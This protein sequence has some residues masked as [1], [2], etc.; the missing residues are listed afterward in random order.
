MKNFHRV[1]PIVCSRMAAAGALLLAV[2]CADTTSDPIDDAELAA[3]DSDAE[4]PSTSADALTQHEYQGAFPG[5]TVDISLAGDDVVLDW[6]QAGL[7]GDGT[8]YRSEDP[9][10]LADLSAGD[11]PPAG[12]VSLSVDPGAT[13]LVDA[14]AAS[15]SQP[16]PLYYYRVLSESNNGGA[17]LSTMVMK[18]TTATGSG[19]NKFGLCMMN[20]FEYAKDLHSMFGDSLVAIYR[21]DSVSQSYEGW[22]P[23]WGV[24]GFE[25]GLGQVFVAQ[26]DGSAPAFHSMVGVVPTDEEFAV[27]GESGFNW[28][29]MPAMYDG[30]DA[31]YW[32]EEAGF[33]GVARWNNTSQ[34]K[35][36][37]WGE[38]YQEIPMEACGTYD[39]V[40]PENACTKN[41]DCDNGKFCHFVEEATCGDTAPGLCLPKPLGCEGQ[42][43]PVCGCDEQTYDSKCDAH[44]AGVS[45]ASEGECA[46][47]TDGDGDPDPTDCAPDD[48]SIHAG[49]VD[50]CNGLDDDCDGVADQDCEAPA[51]ELTPTHPPVDTPASQ[52]VCGRF[53]V[54]G[55]MPDPHQINNL[56]TYMNA[57]DNASAVEELHSDINFAQ[58]GNGCVSEGDFPGATAVPVGGAGNLGTRL[59][60]YLNIPAPMTWTL[61][62][63]GNDAIDVRIGGNSV[64][65]L[66]WGGLG[67]KRTV[68][69]SFPE[70]GLYPLEVQWSSNQICGI[71]PLEFGHAFSVI[72]GDNDTVH[73]GPG[74]GGCGW[75]AATDYTF[76]DSTW[77]V[78]STDGA[79]IDCAQCADDG[80][81]GVGEACN[82]AGLCQ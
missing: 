27:T 64:A 16:T 18:A 10:A 71:D 38:G 62:V 73:C 2:G 37:H 35:D 48:A 52:G 36:W 25:L 22:Q 41:T 29:T 75:S 44:L 12:V 76:I 19:Y 61:A 79:A 43:E 6:S 55:G 39:F 49:A 78:P 32:V 34:T 56:P 70:A 21:W 20:G 47:D 81:C 45:V 54:M 51:I 63:I 67:W 60:G 30:P 66:S 68:G 8:V 77:Y 80:D 9:H 3:E 33:W 23:G 74:Q 50:V 58:F 69:V 1:L 42:P 4:R 15:T 72:P 46:P 57:L 5:F 31:S 40:L 65:A 13:T 17:S 24:D 59:R 82:D 28:A 7:G 26:L 53:A 14:G 11:P